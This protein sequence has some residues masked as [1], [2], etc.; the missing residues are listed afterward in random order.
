MC[1]RSILSVAFLVAVLALPACGSTQPLFGETPSA[2]AAGKGGDAKGETGKVDVKGFVVQ[3]G[4]ELRASEVKN[5]DQVQAS[6][7]APSLVLNLVPDFS[8][9]VKGD[10]VVQSHAAVINMA[11]EEY[12][13]AEA[14]EA[15]AAAKSVL[16]D[17]RVAL[18]KRLTDLR[19]E[20]SESAAAQVT[21]LIYHPVVIMSNG[22]A[23]QKLDSQTAAAAA[24]GLLAAILPQL[25]EATAALVAA[26][27]AKAVPAPS[28]DD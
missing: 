18:A 3:P 9:A 5:E 11:L 14:A 6:Q 21:H 17:E 1:F 8:A 25:D 24:K 7:A 26:E 4:G 10:A 12:R 2:S 13:T 23:A 28:E 22:E 20:L 15:K 27:F 16:D 19:T